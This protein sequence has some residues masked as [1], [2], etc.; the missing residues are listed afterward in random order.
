MF[1]L[2]VT[3]RDSFAS[4]G[5]LHLYKEYQT[6]ITNSSNCHLNPMGDV[7][8]IFSLYMIQNN[9][10]IPSKLCRGS[11][12]EGSSPPPPPTHFFTVMNDFSQ[13]TI[14]DNLITT[15]CRGSTVEGV[16]FLIQYT[17]AELLSINPIK[18]VKCL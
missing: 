10:E 1:D 2:I 15:L 11:I 7:I 5:S 6:R 16:L 8:N 14:H 9:D 3:C 13:C 12:V 4:A 17:R 18:P